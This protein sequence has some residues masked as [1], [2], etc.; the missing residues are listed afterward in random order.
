M[1]KSVTIEKRADDIVSLAP[2]ETKPGI[3]PTCDNSPACV[4]L[5]A[6]GGIVTYCEEYYDTAAITLRPQPKKAEIKPAEPVQ[7]KGLCVNCEK[8]KTCGYS[9]PPEGTWHCEEYE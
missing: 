1:P 7:A 3:C 6:N 9:R 8:Q 2:A 5:K 4:Y